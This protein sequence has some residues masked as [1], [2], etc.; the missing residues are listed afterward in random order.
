M[1]ED[2]PEGSQ[3]DVQE[4]GTAQAME[5]MWHKGKDYH[6]AGSDIA[7]IYR[8]ATAL[9]VKPKDRVPSRRLWVTAGGH[10]SGGRRGRGR[11]GRFGGNHRGMK[12]RGRG[13]GFRHYKE[14]DAMMS[15]DTAMDENGGGREQVTYDD[16]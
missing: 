14:M 11:G 8:M 3:I 10:T 12:R 4:D 13:R 5:V 15:V 1:P 7:I 2:V 9:D 16:L 6:K